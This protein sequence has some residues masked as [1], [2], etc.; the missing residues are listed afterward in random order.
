M[1]QENT[2]PC[3]CSMRKAE[4]RADAEAAVKTPFPRVDKEGKF[5]GPCESW[6]RKAISSLEALHGLPFEMDPLRLQILIVFYMSPGPY[7]GAEKDGA[8]YLEHRN[9]L[10]ARGLVYVPD[11]TFHRITN[12]GRAYIDHIL[13]T[14]LPEQR[15]MMP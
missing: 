8:V 9:A 3:T 2:E 11:G 5:P 13:K 7:D 1:G 14:P 15:W 12:R 10:I 6:T 4:R